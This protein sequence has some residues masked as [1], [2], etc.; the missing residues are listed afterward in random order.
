MARSVRVLLFV[1]MLLS[2]SSPYSSA[3]VQTGTPQFGSYAGGPDVVNL[4]NLNVE[5]TVPVINKPGRGSN[6]PYNL[7]YDSSVWQPAISNGTLSWVSTAGQ[8]GWKGLQPAGVAY[9]TYALSY[10]TGQCGQNLFYQNWSYSNFQFFDSFGVI[11]SFPAISGSYMSTPGVG[12]CPPSGPTP[13]TQPVTQTDGTGYT[14]YATMQ[15][16]SP[17]VYMTDK[18]GKVQYVAAWTTPPTSGP[19]SSTDRNGNMVSQT[20]GVITDTLNQTALSVI[21]SAPSNTNL[22]YI[23]PSGANASYVVSYKGYIVRT[24]FG[25]SSPA[26]TEYNSGTTQIYLVDKITLPDTSFYQFSYEQTP[27]FSSDVTGRLASVTLPTGGQL[28]YTALHKNL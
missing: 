27:G 10:S 14:M 24:A 20:N 6:Y 1:L 26:I 19:T 12:S 5:I 2:V 22:T 16:N 15:A 13:A 21:G 8:W 3:Q 9:A 7:V 28:I 25:C 11:H 4:A 18:N 17:S 23:A